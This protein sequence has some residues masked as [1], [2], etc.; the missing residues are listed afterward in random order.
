MFRLC[1]L[2]KF[3]LVKSNPLPGVTELAHPP[4]VAGADHLR[5]DGVLLTRVLVTM[6]GARDARVGRVVPVVAGGAGLTRGPR[7]A[8]G[9]L[10]L[11]SLVT[12]PGS[13]LVTENI[14]RG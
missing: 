11:L 10:T 12:G 5:L 7:V 8:R 3:V 14:Q 13:H 6:A 4:P 2:I 9:T 1:V